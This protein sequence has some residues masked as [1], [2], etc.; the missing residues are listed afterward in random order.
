MFK[1][2]ILVSATLALFSG[3]VFAQTQP[4]KTTTYPNIG[5]TA[6]AS[7]VKA[8]DIDVR[9]DFLGLPKGSGTVSK[10]ADIWEAKCASCHGSFGEANNVFSPLIGGTTK[11]DIKTGRVARLNDDATR[12]VQP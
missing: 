1:S 8:W 6:T 2:K 5:R 9:P 4:S 10:G 7:E 3:A 12:V 11:D